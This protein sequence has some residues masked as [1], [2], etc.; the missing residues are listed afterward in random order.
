MVIQD[1][2]RKLSWN[3][4]MGS[5]EW[6]VRN[7]GFRKGDEIKLLLV[8]HQVN[9]PSMYA[10]MEASMC[11]ISFI[12]SFFFYFLRWIWIN[13]RIKF[14]DTIRDVHGTGRD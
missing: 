2:S 14:E 1:G 11:K 4:G 5:I 6:M 8:L 10:L 13:I 7:C 9:N 3:G 12:F